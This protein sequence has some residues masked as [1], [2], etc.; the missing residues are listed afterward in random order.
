LP[1]RGEG[2]SHQSKLS[3]EII[4]NYFSSEDED[5]EIAG[6]QANQAPPTGYV[7]ESTQQNVPEEGFSFQ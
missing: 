5:A 2:S 7:F 1:R 3:S 6:A 4:D